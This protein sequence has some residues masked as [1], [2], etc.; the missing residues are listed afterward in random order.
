MDDSKQNWKERISW[1]EASGLTRK[2]IAEICGMS[3]SALCDVVNG[4]TQE[5]R[6]MAAVRL[7]KESEKHC[8]VTARK[9]S[10]ESKRAA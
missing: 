3:Y 7:Y 2:E 8:P 9:P 10:A 4:N 5:P 1:C 6:G